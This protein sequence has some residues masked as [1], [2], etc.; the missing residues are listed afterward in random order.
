VS[1][2][3]FAC[4]TEQEDREKGYKYECTRHYSPVLVLALLLKLREFGLAAVMDQGEN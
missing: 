3:V 4:D 1:L 2:R